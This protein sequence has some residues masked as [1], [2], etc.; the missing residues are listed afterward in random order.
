MKHR[1]IALTAGALVGAALATSAQAGSW[2]YVP[3]SDDAY[4]TTSRTYVYD[5]SPA[6]VAPAPAPAQRRV[7]QQTA[8]GTSSGLY[9]QTETPVNDNCT[10]H[11]ERGLFG[12]WEE[13]R[14]C[15]D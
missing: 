2:V 7:Y 1:V 3:D 12:G 11:R 13:T 14:Y 8:P 4:T 5:R 10:Y 15:P 9:I 6:Y